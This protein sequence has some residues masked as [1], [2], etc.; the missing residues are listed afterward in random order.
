LMTPRGGAMSSPKMRAD[1]EIK[2]LI[3]R[4]D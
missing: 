4:L 1:R 2:R 3:K